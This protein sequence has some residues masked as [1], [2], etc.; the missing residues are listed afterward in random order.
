MSISVVQGVYSVDLGDDNNQLPPI[1]LAGGSAYL[2]ITIEGSIMA[3][4]TKI[5]SVAYALQA[6][7]VTGESSVFTSTGN[8]GIGT[9]TPSTKLEVAGTVSANAFSGDGSGL[10]NVPG[11]STV[12]G[13]YASADDDSVYVNAD[14][15]VGIGTTAPASKLD[16]AG[17]IGLSTNAD[18][19]G[20]SDLISWVPSGAGDRMR[21][22]A[23]GTGGNNNFGLE[24][25]EVESNDMLIFEIN[26]GQGISFRSGGGDTKV[27]MLN[28]GNFG[29]G[30]VSPTGM[31]HVSANALVVNSDGAIGIGTTAPQSQLH[32]QKTEALG[33]ND[34]NWIGYFSQTMDD[35][36]EGGK[37]GIRIGKS[38]S[39]S[40]SVGIAAVAESAW[41][42]QVGMALYTGDSVGNWNEKV[43]IKSNGNVGI[44]T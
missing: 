23:S 30:N 11:A 33:A 38:G 42:N 40:R 6:G 3:P 29:I 35:T 24:L 27:K 39:P 32:V 1:A 12:Y 14:G 15:K 5:D 44:G 2:Q 26:D 13:A 25:Q 16:V 28:N 43:R 21:I 20:W 18:I 7:A 9:T 22:Y 8:V 10:T 34:E 4:R 36:S 31:L 41:G 17:N 37:V 19:T